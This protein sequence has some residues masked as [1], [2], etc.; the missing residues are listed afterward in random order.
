MRLL[1]TRLTIAAVV[2]AFVLPL[3]PA[4]AEI[5]EQ[6]L[7]K[8]NGD[9]FTKTDLEQRQVLVLRQR[10]QQIDL[11]TEAGNAQL[12][13]A[14][15]EIT[16]QIIVDAVNEMVIV[17]RG[18]ELGYK[19]SE[20][21]FKSVVDNIKK[22]NKIQTEEDFQAA[23]KSENMTM[24]DLR[25]NLE[26]SMISQRVEQNEVFSKIGIS[27]DEARRYYDSHLNEFTSPQSVTLREVLVIVPT[28]GKTFDA[29]VAEAAKARAEE[30]RTRVTTGKESF[31]KLATEVS[32]SGSKANGGLIGPITLDDISPELRTMIQGMKTGDVSPVIRTARGYQILRLES[33]TAKQTM[34]F[35]QARE[36]ISD[37]VFTDKRKGELLKY[38]EKLRS[39][40]IIEWKN[41]DV[42]RAFEEGLKQQ[43]I[44]PAG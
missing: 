23:L 30:L 14:L 42:R 12:K 18:R 22:E 13:K 24:S 32:E 41:Q 28:D 26:R 27:E 43:S 8:V 38:L 16:P 39:Q 29:N 9:I 21:Q 15:E 19:L 4:R 6:I 5:F 37:T 36:K 17:Q 35:E 25:R 2:G 11:K 10:G 34:P 7:V 20:E 44:Q 1:T 33:M 40:A 3:S 31:E